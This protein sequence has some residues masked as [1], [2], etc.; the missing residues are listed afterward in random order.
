MIS[1]CGILRNG[2]VLYVPR[3]HYFIVRMQRSDSGTCLSQETTFMLIL[4]HQGRLGLLQIFRLY[5]FTWRKS[6]VSYI[7]F[8]PTWWMWPG[9]WTSCHQY[10]PRW[11]NISFLRFSLWIVSHSLAWCLLIKWRFIAFN[12]SFRNVDDPTVYCKGLTSCSFTL[13]GPN[14][15]TKNDFYS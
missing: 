4:V 9:F 14:I 5:I 8:K 15:R 7:P 3:I 1:R 6:H 12:N 13:Q 2:R 10:V 11:Q